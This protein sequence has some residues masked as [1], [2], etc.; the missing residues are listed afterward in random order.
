MAGRNPRFRVGTYAWCTICGRP[1]K[2][3]RRSGKFILTDCAPKD[4]V[5]PKTELRPLTARERGRKGSK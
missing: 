3:F 4:G 2:L 1:V 5:D